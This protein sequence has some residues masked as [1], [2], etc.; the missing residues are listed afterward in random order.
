[1]AT[2]VSKFEHNRVIFKLLN[3]KLVFHVLLYIQQADTVQS[4]KRG[5]KME[6]VKETTLNTYILL[7]FLQQH[8]HLP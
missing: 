3:Y 1:M 2:Q 6:G 4:M 5:R 8:I 7:R